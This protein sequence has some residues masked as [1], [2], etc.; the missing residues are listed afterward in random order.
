MNSNKARA[1]LR[2]I[3]RIIPDTRPSGYAKIRFRRIFVCIIPDKNPSGYAKIR[4]RRI[5]V[6][7]IPDTN[8]S[9]YAKIRSRRIFPEDASVRKPPLKK[10]KR[11]DKRT[12]TLE[13]DEVGAIFPTL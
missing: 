10:K 3:A 5:F 9:G 8:P 2:E 13:N 1:N 11:G 6:C 4:S 7:I 12:L